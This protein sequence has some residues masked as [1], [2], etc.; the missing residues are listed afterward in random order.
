MVLPH[1]PLSFVPRS[2]PKGDEIQARRRSRPKTAVKEIIAN[3]HDTS[4]PPDVP[5]TPTGS[6][7]LSR[8]DT[9]ESKAEVL[10]HGHVFLKHCRRSKP[11]ARFVWWSKVSERAII[12]VGVKKAACAKYS[13]KVLGMGV[14]IPNQPLPVRLL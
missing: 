14:E 13:F 10:K 11:H 4:S 2:T 3:A 6:P 12:V 9:E 1:F 7:D 8:V 5:S